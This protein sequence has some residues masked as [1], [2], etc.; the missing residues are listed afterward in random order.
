MR[1]CKIYSLQLMKLADRLC[2]RGVGV[3]GNR[4]L[5]LRERFIHGITDHHL[6]REMRRYALEHEESLEMDS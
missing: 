2:K 4:D 3:I 5:V 6:R 1:H